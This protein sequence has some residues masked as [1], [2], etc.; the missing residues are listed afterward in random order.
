MTRIS[1]KNLIEDVLG[2][3]PEALKASDTRKTVE[4]WTS[5][6]G[7][8]ILTSFVSGLGLEMDADLG[9]G[10]VVWNSVAR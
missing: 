9:P 5:V 2:V 8:Q 1:F 4:G 10:I 6:A 3:A 7:V